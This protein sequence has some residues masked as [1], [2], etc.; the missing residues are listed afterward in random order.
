M[1]LMYGKRKVM[2][3]TNKRKAKKFGVRMRR[4][5]YKIEVGKRNNIYFVMAKKKK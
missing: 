2:P 5:G 3:F 4:K 1:E